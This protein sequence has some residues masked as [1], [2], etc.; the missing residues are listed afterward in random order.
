MTKI[1]VLNTSLMLK[2]KIYPPPSPLVLREGE[3]AKFSAMEGEFRLL[4]KIKN[5]IQNFHL[6]FSQNPISIKSPNKITKKR[7]KT[8]FIKSI[9]F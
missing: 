6:N 5:P 4:R 2:S 1:K 8:R 3:K 7:K 9:K